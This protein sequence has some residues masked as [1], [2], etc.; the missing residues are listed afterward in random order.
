MLGIRSHEGGN[1]LKEGFGGGTCSRV[2]GR[3]NAQYVNMINIS[4]A[5]ETAGAQDQAFEERTTTPQIHWLYRRVLSLYNCSLQS[6]TY[7]FQNQAILKN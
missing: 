1:R 5:R 2:G 3:F 6:H 7:H 4:N